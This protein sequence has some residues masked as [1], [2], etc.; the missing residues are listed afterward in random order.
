MW[1]WFYLDKSR[2]HSCHIYLSGK[3]EIKDMLYAILIRHG[4]IRRCYVSWQ[5][6]GSVED[7]I[8]N[9]PMIRLIKVVLSMIIW[10]NRLMF[11][12]VDVRK[13]NFITIINFLSINDFE[14]PYPWILRILEYLCR[15]RAQKVAFQLHFIMDLIYFKLPN[16]S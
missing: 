1:A 9:K 16:W 2:W 12:Y 5:D 11:I 14:L 8:L 15:K 6:T 4:S 13:Y 3:K 10:L 7:Y